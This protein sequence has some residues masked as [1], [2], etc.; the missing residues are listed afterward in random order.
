[1]INAI[2]SAL[3][4]FVPA[5]WANAMPLLA[6][7]LPILRDYNQPLDFHKTWRGKRIFGSHKTWRGLIF[8]FLSTIPFM[9]MQVY[10]YEHSQS[11]R[12]I[13]YINYSEINIFLLSFLFSFGALGGDAIRSFF[14]R[15]SGVK[16]GETWFPF[17]QADFVIGGLLLSSLYVQLEPGQYLLVGILAFLLHPVITTIGYFL[18][19]R[20]RPI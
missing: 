10:L 16:P 17:D 1:M 20:E 2:L 13:S 8:A 19:I 9:A 3:W 14:K 12:N 6:A 18:K 11:V 5:A 7:K 4:F 15:Q